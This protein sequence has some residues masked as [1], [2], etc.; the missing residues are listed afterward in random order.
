MRGETVSDNPLPAMI[1]AIRDFLNAEDLDATRRVVEA[2]HTI[3]FQPEAETI[4]EQNIEQAK[5]ENKEQIVHLLELYLALLRTCQ[6]KGIE[7]AFEDLLRMIQPAEES[8]PFDAE[9]IPKSIHALQG[10]PT[11]ENGT[12]PVPYHALRRNI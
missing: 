3:L 9:L 11:G 7:Q 8:L 5:T 1:Q 12:C 4:F 10:E 6:Q 2:H